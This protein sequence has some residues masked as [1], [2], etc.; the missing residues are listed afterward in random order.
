MADFLSELEGYPDLEGS[1]IRATKIHKVLKQMIKLEHI[2]LEEE[3]KFRDRSAKL[4]AKW[5][6]TLS[7]DGPPD[8][9]A[10]DKS[11]EKTTHKPEGKRAESMAEESAPTM[12]GVTK[13]TEEQV[14]KAE[15][16]DA[17][18]P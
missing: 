10:E 17:A 1:I 2:P 12:N 6:D 13:G 4:L 16:G 3:F 7:N 14:R 8:E 11:E 15:S 18:A 9:K 5:N